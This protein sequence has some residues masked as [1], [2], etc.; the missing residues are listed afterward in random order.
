MAW[1]LFSPTGL[2]LEQIFGLVGRLGGGLGRA[3]LQRRPMRLE[4]G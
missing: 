2:T 4:G 3:G 1:S